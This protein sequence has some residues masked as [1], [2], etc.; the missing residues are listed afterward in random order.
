MRF[1]TIPNGKGYMAGFYLLLGIIVFICAGTLVL[2]NVLFSALGIMLFTGGKIAWDLNNALFPTFTILS[3]GRIGLLLGLVGGIL[4][5]VSQ[6]R[7]W[8]IPTK[9]TKAITERKGL[10]YLLSAT[11]VLYDILSTYYFIIGGVFISDIG[12]ML[13]SIGVSVAMFCIGPIMFFIWS[14]ETIVSNHKEGFSAIG[15][16]IGN[17]IGF[18]GHLLKQ[19]QNLADW[20]VKDETEE[21]KENFQEKQQPGRGRGR[22]T[23]NNRD[24]TESEAI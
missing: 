23:N 4:A 3:G 5:G 2:S 21:I 17:F 19:V 13:L 10:F 18:G 16:G 15:I 20:E 8:V 9:G 24:F 11:F 12:S 7:L 1:L 6:M 22:P 14:M